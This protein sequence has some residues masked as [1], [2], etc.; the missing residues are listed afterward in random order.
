MK[1]KHLYILGIA[2][3]LLLMSTRKAFAKVVDNQE[4]RD[5]DPQGCGHFGASR[6]SRKHNGVDVI[7][8][9]NQ[10]IKSPISGKITRYPFPDADD[11]SKKGIEIINDTY[12]VKIFYVVGIVP[13]NTVVSAGQNIA[14][15]QD[16][17]TKY[18]AGMTNHAHVE[19]YKK[20]GNKWVLIDPTN[21]F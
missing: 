1:K 7:T 4:F 3:I 21:L 5:C 14:K 15:A 20:V 10:L 2:T 11:L 13:I 9:P 8:T 16:I 17:T 19:T 6:G 12:K 18:S